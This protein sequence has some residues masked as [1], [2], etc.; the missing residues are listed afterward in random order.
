MDKVTLENFEQAIKESGSLTYSVSTA[1]V[2]GEA[3][4]GKT[5]LKSL[6]MS[7]PYE[8]VSTSVIEAP[9]IAYRYASTGGKCWKLVN[10]DEMDQK[11]IAE[12]QQRASEGSALTDSDT[13]PKNKDSDMNSITHFDTPTVLSESTDELPKDATNMPNVISQEEQELND[14]VHNDQEHND[15]EHDDREHNDQDDNVATT[16]TGETKPT[17]SAT[18]IKN[19][20]NDFLKLC[21]K[22]YGIDRFDLHKE[23]LYLIDS[24]GQIQFQ[25]LLLAFMPCTTTLIL[26]VNLSKNLS[27]L[28]SSVMKLS[29]YKTI[30][31]G[32]KYSLKVEDV[33]KQVLSAVASNAQQYKSALGDS[34][35]IDIPAG[36]LQL[37]AV[38]THR[39]KYDELKSK[40]EKIETLTDKQTKLHLILSKVESTCDIIYADKSTLSPLHEIDGR[41]AAVNCHYTDEAI[42]KICTSLKNRKYTIKVPLMW[43]Y[44]SVLLRNKAEEKNGVLT[45]SSCEAFGISLGFKKAADVHSALKFFHTLNVLFYYHDSPLAKDIVFVKLDSLINIIRQLVIKI[46]QFHCDKTLL[47]K[48]MRQK[49]A[50]GYL[51]VQLIKTT[52]A[53]QKIKDKNPDLKLS[54]ILLELFKHL[55]IAAA[56]KHLKKAAAHKD[57]ESY[58]LVMPALLPIKDLSDQRC[59]ILRCIQYLWSDEKALSNTP[60]LFYFENAVPMG[61]FC[62]VIVHLLGN[63]WRIALTHKEIYSNYFTLEKNFLA[64]SS[65][66]VVIVEKFN[67]IEIHCTSNSRHLVKKDIHDAINAVRTEKFID[68]E[69]PITAFYCPKYPSCSEERDHIARVEVK[70]ERDDVFIICN[71]K[72]TNID[73]SISDSKRKQYWAWF[74]SEEKIKLLLNIRN[75]NNFLKKHGKL[76]FLIN[77]ILII[78]VGKL[79]IV[80]TIGILILLIFVLLLVSFLFQG[81]SNH[82][83]LLIILC[84]IIFSI[85]IG[86]LTNEGLVQDSNFGKQGIYNC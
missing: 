53:F 30:K 18:P 47:S 68:Y 56:H 74:M 86:P 26:V 12:I 45:V 84:Y 76:K 40:R 20:N 2:Q 81:S 37:I 52:E 24:G 21:L 25:K 34:K 44:F 70:G 10:D 75:K 41:K 11:I 42:E 57:E 8:E 49:V 79:C 15:Q 27:D 43:H 39:D 7:L 5:C 17:T 58:D 14:Q 63:E 13:A 9:C 82:Q 4:I 3:Q 64:G 69:E 71:E 78:V 60:L 55:K 38:G 16:K 33:L 46:C 22:K 61:L 85:I 59:C 29:Q 36:N 23:W 54:I 35:Y 50:L 28:S 80:I 65:L 67:C 73:E 32:S 77:F 66:N 83:D 31:F 72:K 6:I 1:I 48:E 19:A 62:A 51:P